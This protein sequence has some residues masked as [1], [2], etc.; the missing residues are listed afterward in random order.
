MAVREAA[1]A[2]PS[3]ARPEG[4]SGEGRGGMEAADLA[5]IPEKFPPTDT[6]GCPQGNLGAQL[7]LPNCLTCFSSV[8]GNWPSA[9]RRI[10]RY[11]NK[12]DTCL[13]PQDGGL[14]RFPPFRQVKSVQNFSKGPKEERAS[15]FT[16][17]ADDTKL[18]KTTGRWKKKLR[19][20]LH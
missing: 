7:C 10:A 15:M 3:P 5:L 6:E 8:R 12:A 13:L 17:L 4:T 16:K 20:I 1:E 14:T 2:P 19:M 9:N 11:Q 18:A